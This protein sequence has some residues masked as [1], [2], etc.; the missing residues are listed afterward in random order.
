MRAKL[1]LVLSISIFFVV[2]CGWSQ[3]NYWKSIAPKAQDVGNAKVEKSSMFTFEEKLFQKELRSDLKPTSEKL[4]YFPEASGDLIGF[5]VKETPIFHP[6]L[7]KKY[8]NIKSYTGWSRDRKHKIRFSSSQNGI[9]GMLISVA[10]DNKATFIEKEKKSNNYIA[11]RGR[12]R[13]VSKDGFTC[14]TEDV[15]K[16]SISMGIFSKAL[17]DDQTL[18]TYR[19][20]ISATGEY[21]QYHGG[22]IADALAAINATLTRVNEVFETDLSVHLQLIANNDLVIFTDPDT[23]PYTGNLNAQAQST[24]T[25]T[26]GEANYDVGHV[27]QNG[28]NNGNAGFI[29]SVCSDN[30]K[31]SAFSSGV[32]PQGDLFDIDFVSHELGHQFGA[33]HTWSFETEDTGVQAE[34]ASGTTIM[35][36]AGIVEGNDVEPNGDDYFHYNSIL[37]ITNYLQTI[38]CG[39]TVSLTNLPPVISPLPD[40]IIPKGTAF[41]LDADV[42]DADASDV[43]TYTWEQID[44]GVVV[45]STF[46]PENVSGANFRSQK[47]TTSP[48]RYFPK[49]SRIVQGNLT[50]TNPAES[51]AWETVA[52]IEREFNFAFTARDNAVGG[53]QVASELTKVTTV[54][55]AGPFVITSQTTNETYLA[56]SIQQI[57]WDVANTNNAPVNAQLVDML[58][59]VDGGLT[60]PFLIA[61]DI[62][63]TGSAAIQIPGDATSQARIMVKAANNIF[64]AVNSSNFTIQESQVVLNFQD[65][66]FET[67]QP[68]DV[69]I[70]FTFETY[71]G[72]SEEVTFSAINTPPGLS[73]DFSPASASSNNTA[74][75]LTFSNTGSVAI[76]SYPITIRGAA[77]GLTVENTIDLNIFN[78]SF[79][80]VTLLSPSDLETNTRIN[81]RLEWQFEPN[82]TQYDIEIATDVG[83]TN[84]VESATVDFEFYQPNSL[85]SETTYFWRVRPRND[86]GIGSFGTPFSFTTSPITCTNIDGQG[87]PIEISTGNAS[88][89]T[90]TIS[91]LQDLPISDLNVNLDIS[92]SFLEDLI[93]KLTSPSGTTITLLSKNCG[94]LNNITA[95]FDDDGLPISCS[96]TSPA[97]SGTIMPLG[98]LASFNGESS[99]GDW[100]LEIQDTANGDG[101]SLDSFSLALCVEGILRPDEDE[102]GV[103]DDGDDLCLGTPKGVEVDVTGCPIYRFA[104]DNFS[105][106]AQSE[107]CRNNNDGLIEIDAVDDSISYSA[108]L[109]GDNGSFNGDFTDVFEFENLLGGTYQLCITGYNGTITFEESCFDIQ[110][111]EPEILMVDSVILENSSEAI[112]SLQ[113]GTLYNVE[114]NGVVTQT[115]DSE[116][117]IDLLPGTNKLKVFTN[118]PCQGSFEETFFIS[119]STEIYPNPVQERL[120][121]LL[122]NEVDNVIVRLFDANGRLVYLK[123]ERVEGSMLELEFDTFPIGIYFLKIEGRNFKEEFKVLKK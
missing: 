48:E 21:T 108:T 97:I 19:I 40:Y 25:S 122:N 84:I 53:G 86:C 66:D 75:T 73:V 68:D 99:L 95:I 55:A 30:R 57:T 76:G 120:N 6:D 80:D 118:L 27:F 32:D 3:D 15:Q 43:L 88:T 7:A 71:G 62:P 51:S 34:P 8:P 77:T 67:C 11:Y 37:Q 114:V 23:D 35:G 4:V 20:A 63:N 44:D 91:V 28:P 116:I 24:L 70:P 96:N 117:K 59:S 102:D 46:G 56:G 69:I 89:I 45:T 115:E 33:N 85:L 79:G 106:K 36:Y 14:K 83:F 74:I 18:R 42:T 22:T 10:D 121:V 13:A 112:I 104:A 39:Q 90:A 12:S 107:S 2:F 9:Q 29:G 103:F 119:S 78:T 111:D 31:G 94:N 65:L 54:N 105:I 93:I 17:V 47:P 52:T 5:T 61:D 64:F 26:I 41:V 81:P 1:H 98:S 16:N 87:L 82:S 72:F 113:G 50:Q 109:V 101:G 123:S 58:L 100:V 49:L 110:I 92:H 38:G 60:F